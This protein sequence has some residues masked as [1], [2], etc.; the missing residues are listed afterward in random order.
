MTKVE[1]STGPTR[2]LFM[3]E[4]LQGLAGVRGK[5]RF[6][7]ERRMRLF[8]VFLFFGGGGFADLYGSP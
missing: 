3:S 6:V 4:D 2:G 5:A 1:K 7:F 8:L